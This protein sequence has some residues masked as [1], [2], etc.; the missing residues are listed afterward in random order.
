MS[1]MNCCTP[2]P[3]SKRPAQSNITRYTLS[4]CSPT[5]NPYGKEKEILWLLDYYVE[6]TVRSLPF[7]TCVYCKPVLDMKVDKNAEKL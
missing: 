4:T 3:T 5:S 2:Y 1:H 6:M 7:R